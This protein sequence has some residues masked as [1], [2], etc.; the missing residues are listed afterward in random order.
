GR[1]AGFLLTGSA[2]PYTAL[3]AAVGEATAQRF[4][5]VSSENREL[6][7]AELLDPGRVDC[8][9]L[10]E[11]SWIAALPGTGQEEAL[12]DS[13]GRLAALGFDLSFREGEEM[14]RAAGSERLAGGLFQPRDG[15]LDPVRLCRGIAR[16]SGALVRTGFPVRAIEPAGERV[17]L[18]SDAG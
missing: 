14:R 16:L 11:G 15:G 4:W 5:E 13:A 7:R 12:R 2:E 8:E 6:L 9:F 1:N 18:V 17:R 10:P 3:V